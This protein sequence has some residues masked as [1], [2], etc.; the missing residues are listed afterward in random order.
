MTPRIIIF[1]GIDC[2]GKT[3]L[4]KEFEIATNFEHVCV[5]RFFLTS[6]IYNKVF[7]R[8][9]S[10]E[11][12]LERQLWKFLFMFHP[13]VVILQ[14]Q[15]EIVLKRIKERGDWVLK[16][17]KDAKL[18]HHEYDKFIAANGTLSPFLVLKGNYKVE[19]NVTLILE[20]LVHDSKN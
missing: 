13:L 20:K 7:K 15:F 2:A 12:E 18:I 19:E 6:I 14:P 11:Q 8:H 9:V 3:T 4:K 1:E 10:Q 17:E 16:K 5:D